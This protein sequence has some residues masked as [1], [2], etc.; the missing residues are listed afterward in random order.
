MK[1]IKGDL[2]RAGFCRVKN[3]FSSE[4]LD[5][6]EI[7]ISSMMEK[8]GIFL[9]RL[10]TDMSSKFYPECQQ[11][12]L[13]RP[14][15]L[16]AKLRKS[17]IYKRCHSIAKEYFGGRAYYLYDHAIFKM[18]NSPTITP[19]HQD[20]AYLGADVDIP[21]LHFWIPFQDTGIDNGAMQFVVGRHSELLKHQL[22]YQQN[23]HVLTVTDLP[24][25]DI[26]TM[27]I[28]RGDVSLHTNLTLHSSLANNSELPR[29]AWIIHFGKKPEFYKW[30]YKVKT[31]ISKKPSL[32]R[33]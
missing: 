15:L 3:V 7:I 24:A 17:L 1:E 25:N 33:W 16:S 28:N 6:C 20:Q 12:E 18:P 11:L 32:D 2:E 30:F 13:T 23:S 29:K 26:F 5:Y 27:N 19:W 21:S 9:D 8:K 4:D 22:A 10:K 31:L 14:A